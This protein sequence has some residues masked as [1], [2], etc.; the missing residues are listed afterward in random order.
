MRQRAEA[1]QVRAREDGSVLA[2]TDV[3]GRQLE[4]YDHAHAALGSG[5]AQLADRHHDHGSASTHIPRA[6]AEPKRLDFWRCDM[7]VITE[8]VARRRR[9]SASDMAVINGLHRRTTAVM[10]E[11]AMRKRSRQQGNLAI[12]GLNKKRQKERKMKA[13]DN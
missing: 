9:R 2:I 5:R 11:G 4:G 12:N 1:K 10:G 3:Y 8:R 6:E 13:E 7:C